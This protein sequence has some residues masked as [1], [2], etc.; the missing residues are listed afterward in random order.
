MLLP[1]LAEVVAPGS[2][3]AQ[4]RGG[5]GPGSTGPR[6]GPDTLGAVDACETCQVMQAQSIHAFSFLGWGEQPLKLPLQV[7]SKGRYFCTLGRRTVTQA[8]P[9]EQVPFR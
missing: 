2:L 3:G 1:I 5:G 7:P 8:C 4:P 9:E 6:P